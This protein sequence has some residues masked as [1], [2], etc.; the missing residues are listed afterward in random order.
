MQP[1]QYTV[2]E[3][4]GLLQPT[5]PTL[6]QGVVPGSHPPALEGPVEGPLRRIIFI[7]QTVLRLYSDRLHHV[8]LSLCRGPSVAMQRCASW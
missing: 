5:N 4:T 3:V 2:T 8:R 6:L 1:M 7:D